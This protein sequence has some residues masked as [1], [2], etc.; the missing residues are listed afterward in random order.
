MR[1]SMLETLSVITDNPW[2]F[3]ISVGVIILV[4]C[5]GFKYDVYH[6][7]KLE[8]YE[9]NLKAV[10]ITY[11]KD[12]NA[13]QKEATMSLLVEKNQQLIKDSNEDM[14]AADIG[15][16]IGVI[17]LLMGGAAG[18]VVATKETQTS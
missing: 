9:Q 8:S 7:Y 16:W 14:L 3:A 18:L 2:K 1:F 4:F 15:I 13:S 12:M 17:A 5:F 10:E 11:N 6:S